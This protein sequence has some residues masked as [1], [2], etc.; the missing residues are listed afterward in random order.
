MAEPPDELGERIKWCRM[1]LKREIAQL[2]K[3]AA[4]ADPPDR[5]PRNALWLQQIGDSLV[6]ASGSIDPGVAEAAIVNVHTGR[7]ETVPLNPKLSVEKNAALYHKKSKKALRAD[8]AVTR[9]RTSSETGLQ[10]LRGALQHLNSVTARA[11]LPEIT[12][13]IDSA[14]LL[15]GE[16][17][18]GVAHGGTGNNAAI[19]Y[20]HVSLHGWDIYIGKTDEQNDE[21]S[22]KFAAPADIW[23]HVAGYAG[24]H[25]IIQRPKGAPEPP[26][27]VITAAASLSAWFSKVRNAPF[28][29]VHMAEARNVHKRQ[30]APAGQVMVERWKSLRVAP[31]S[32]DAVTGN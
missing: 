2:E 18:P 7:R 28:A 26:E 15:L 6:K 10:K 12:E 9:E 4:P 11:G 21:L 13:A 32:P 1:L 29:E 5:H 19:P 25:V 17:V 27:P 3:Q 14:F 24:S 20:R 8:A 16:L 31:R 30:G 22:L 23:F